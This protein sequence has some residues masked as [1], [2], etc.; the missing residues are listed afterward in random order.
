M[1]T[2]HISSS[3]H[4][5]NAQ[6]INSPGSLGSGFYCLGS[7]SGEISVLRSS[8]IFPGPWSEPRVVPELR[9]HALSFWP[10]GLL[11]PSRWAGERVGEDRKWWCSHLGRWH[12]SIFGGLWGLGTWGTTKTWKHPWIFLSNVSGLS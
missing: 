10:G 3:K 1:N 6:V 12:S 9:W 2:S 4:L 7:G 11:L 8:I 5:I